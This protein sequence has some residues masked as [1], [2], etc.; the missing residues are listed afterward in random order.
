MNPD[1]LKEMHH[2]MLREHIDTAMAYECD[3]ELCGK[4]LGVYMMD[5]GV[6]NHVCAECVEKERETRKA[7]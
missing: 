3:C 5:E 1:E 6:C 2:A 7:K 4:H